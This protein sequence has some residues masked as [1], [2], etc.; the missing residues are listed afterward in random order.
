VE[1]DFTGGTS[2]VVALDIATGEQLWSTEVAAP[3]YAG[4]TVCS[5]I[6]FS[7]GLD[8][9]VRGFNTAD[10][11]QVF[12]WQTT[13]INGTFAAVGDMLFIPAGGLLIPSDE[14]QEEGSK[15]PAGVYAL[16]LGL[17]TGEATPA[18]SPT[19]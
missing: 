11:T 4:C 8:G 13:G 1:F 16:K 15:Q 14:T 9:V 17:G 2:E 18:A 3:L 19:S 12:T 7:A 10:G 6:V 5:D